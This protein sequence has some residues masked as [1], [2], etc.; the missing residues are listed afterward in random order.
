MNDDDQNFDNA[1]EDI[2]DV[3]GLEGRPF[4]PVP[5]LKNSSINC[6]KSEQLCR[7]ILE[8]LQAEVEFR[9]REFVVPPFWNYFSNPELQNATDNVK[10]KIF[11]E[12]SYDT[13]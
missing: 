2:R 9:L 5:H 12:V 6:L 4:S 7:K 1:W 11:H 8:F 3:F 13:T 10:A